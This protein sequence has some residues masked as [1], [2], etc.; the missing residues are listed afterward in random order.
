MSL[1]VDELKA[2]I[3]AVD[4]DILKYRQSGALEKQ[5]NAL[6]DYKDYMIDELRALQR[7]NDNR[8]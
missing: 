4:A 6:I 3:A 2:K 5:I 7:N 1:T 8:K